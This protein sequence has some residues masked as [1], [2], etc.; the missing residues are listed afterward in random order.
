LVDER[1]A[2]AAERQ[3]EIDARVRQIDR[4]LKSIVN[5]EE[6]KAQ[7]EIA[8]P[9]LNGLAKWTELAAAKWSDPP[10]QQAAMEI[11]AY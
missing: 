6:R 11:L 5:L 7:K 10:R 1:T 8:E 3:R 4:E 9:L 2:A